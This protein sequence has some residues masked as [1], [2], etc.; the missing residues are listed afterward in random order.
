MPVTTRESIR[1]ALACAEAKIFIDDC[2]L[3]TVAE[4]FLDGLTRTP[5]DFESLRTMVHEH[6]MGEDENA[7][8]PI[9]HETG[10]TDEDDSPFWEVDEATAAWMEEAVQK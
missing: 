3:R 5:D 2:K 9:W 6:M 8:K 7:S 4:M 10:T 1:W